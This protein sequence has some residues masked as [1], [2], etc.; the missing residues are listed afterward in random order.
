MTNLSQVAKVLKCQRTMT[1]GRWKG[2]V[3]LAYLRGLPLI[4]IIACVDLINYC[5]H[6]LKTGT[7][8]ESYI[9][10]KN[11]RAIPGVMEAGLS[12]DL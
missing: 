5:Q 12:R 1:L 4:F 9:E 8:V 2:V 6:L 11:E 7:S 3:G 10:W